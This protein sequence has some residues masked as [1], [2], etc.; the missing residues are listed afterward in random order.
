MKTITHL[1]AMKE[2]KEKIAML[3][4]YDASFAH[5][6]SEAGIDILLIGDTLGSVICGYPS[7]LPVTLDDVIYHTRHVVRTNKNALVIADMP[8]MTYATPDQAMSSA[9]Q[10]MQAGAAMVKME[11]GAWLAETIS[12]MTERGI[13]VCG[14]LGLVPQSVHAMGGYKIQ[15]RSEAQVERII[16]EAKMLEKAGASLVVLECVTENL[17]ATI[18][19]ILR[20]PVIGIGSGAYCDGQVLV[21]YDMLGIS[22]GKIPSF[23][24][25]FLA[26]THSVS[27]AVK[28]YIQAVKQGTFP[29][30]EH[31]FV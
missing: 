29:A 25:N 19:E 4:A 26:E 7:T 1:Q 3:T 27:D 21:V 22:V 30:K 8:F 16:E 9:A 31:T 12:L 15:G 23:T 11:G 5:V 6:L 13:P 2:K 24:R 18:Q 17:A 10:L 28:A 20:I 14:H